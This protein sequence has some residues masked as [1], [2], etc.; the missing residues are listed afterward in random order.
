MIHPAAAAGFEREADRY[1]TGRPDYPAGVADWLAEDLRLASGGAVLDLGAGTGKFL[2]HLRPTGAQ[3]IAVEPVAAMRAHIAAE[4]PDVE[5]REGT[6]EAIPLLAASVDAV[7]CAQAFHWFATPAA[8]AEIARVLKPGGRLGL[9][10]NVRDN[11]VPWVRRLTTILDEHQG[12]APRHESGQWRDAFPDPHFSDLY[13]REWRHAH[14]GPARY[15]VVDRALSISFIA[16]LPPAQLEQVERDVR[17]LI[18]D[19]PD[20]AD[21]GGHARFP[22]VTRAYWA[23]RIG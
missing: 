1:V 7:I 22:Y 4:Q 13:E 11:E 8:L 15:V 14:S 21:A 17:T 16:A 18:A 6:A 10:W 5:V 19:T 3:L 20:L 23:E 9:I 2:Q 12:D